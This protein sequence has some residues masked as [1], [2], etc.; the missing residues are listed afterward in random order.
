MFGN[1]KEELIR[2]KA[3]ISILIKMASADGNIDDIERKFVEDVARQLGLSVEDIDEVFEYPNKY[4]IKPP[5]PEQERMTILYYL[6]FTMS[7]DGKIDEA[8]EKLCYKVG[9]R[10]GF[11]EYMTR[12][13]IQVM[14][15]Y[16]NKELPSDALLNT[17][18]RHMN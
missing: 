11:N 15:Q 17:I 8:E 1:Y 4:E 12:D 13:L 5:P 7:V 9:L 6:L 16:L 18:K 10:L 3:V 2:R 14:K